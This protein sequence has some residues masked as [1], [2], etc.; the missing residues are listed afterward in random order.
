MNF[1][2]PREKLLRQLTEQAKDLR[3]DLRMLGQSRQPPATVRRKRKVLAAMLRKVERR[4][5][6]VSQMG[7]FPK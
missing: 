3:Y 5:E 1:D 7:L 4:L 6:L 2:Q